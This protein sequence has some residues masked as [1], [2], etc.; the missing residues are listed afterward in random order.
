MRRKLS[1]RLLTGT[2]FV[3]FPVIAFLLMPYFSVFG[4]LL[5][6]GIIVLKF[7]LPTPQRRFMRYQQNIPT[8]K[9][10]SM[11][12]GLV[13]LEGSL[14]SQQVMR[15]P[16]SGKNCIG[17]YHTVTEEKRDSDGKTDYRLVHKEQRCNPFI[18]QDST[19]KVQI[20]ASNID[21]FLLPVKE[22]IRTGRQIL[23]EYRLENGEDYLLIGKAIRRNSE[24]VIT[25]DAL[26]R[27]FG[28][29]PVGNLKRRDK[30]N[31]VLARAR[32]YCIAIALFIAL[33]L[34]LPI[35]VQHRQV[36]IHYSHLLSFFNVSSPYEGSGQ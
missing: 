9:V 5:I 14:V 24:M 3:L 6:V 33:V 1:S 25:R 35:D 15:A 32:Y 4:P 22:E 19:G 34:V 7:I 26:R 12:M 11:A 20:D 10:R 29:A 16:M 27:V 23:R 2:G 28:I 13:E 18:L 17:F 30:L 36:V 31:I 21:F 8:S